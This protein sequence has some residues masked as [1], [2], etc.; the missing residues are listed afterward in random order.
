MIV[1]AQLEGAAIQG[2]GY[3]LSEELAYDTVVRGT[4]LNANLLMYELPTIRDVPLVESVIVS[5]TNHSHSYGAK[6]SERPPGGGIL[7]PSPTRCTT[8]QSRGKWS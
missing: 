7:P 4:P 2:L 5:P 3:A 1:D 8:P 6:G